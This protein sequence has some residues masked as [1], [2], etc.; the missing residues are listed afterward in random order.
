ELDTARTA[1]DGSFTLRAKAPGKFFLQVRRSGYPA[2]E[3]DAIFLQAGE[4]RDDTLY[5]APAA[6]LLKLDVIVDREVS[7]IFGVPASSLAGKAVILPEDIASVSTSTRTASDVVLK[8]GPPFVR[9]LGAGTGRVCYQ[10]RG[11]GCAALYL[12][13]QPIPATI[14]I[15]AHDLEAVAILAPMDVLITVGRNN[16]IVML[17][18]RGMLRTGAR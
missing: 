13:G 8:K 17:F 18:T 3:T 1:A 16:G 14:D 6:S 2:E 12:N 5:V 9:V 10:I 11:A 4:T 7:R 15:P